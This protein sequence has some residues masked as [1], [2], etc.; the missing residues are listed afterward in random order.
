MPAIGY[1]GGI[2]KRL[3]LIIF[4]IILVFPQISSADTVTSG[5][6]KKTMSGN[7]EGLMVATMTLHPD[8]KGN[9]VVDDIAGIVGTIEKIILRTQDDSN[10]TSTLDLYLNDPYGFDILKTNGVGVS[11][12]STLDFD[13]YDAT[14]IVPI[15]NLDLLDIRVQGL[16]GAL[17]ISDPTGLTADLKLYFRR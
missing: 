8:S 2:M 4:I 7:Y 10:T 17:P 11:T 5:T 3:L 16:T 9:V 1:K 15:A 6:F 14:A 12:T 13:I